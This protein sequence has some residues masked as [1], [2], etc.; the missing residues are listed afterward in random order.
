[1]KKD[2][3]SA[4]GI[5]QS[6][7]LEWMQETTNLILAGFSEIEIKERL[8]GFLSNRS[9]SGKPILRSKN[10]TEF[11]RA[12]L[13]KCWVH[14][15]PELIPLRDAGLAILS[16][17]MNNVTP[18]HFGM[19]SAA[20]PY[21]YNVAFHLGRLLNLQETVDA[22]RVLMRIRE[23]Y[24]DKQTITR[25]ADYV[26]RSLIAW[27]LIED[28]DRKG[29]YIRGKRIV[30]EEPQCAAFLLAASFYAVDSRN[31]DF[32]SLRH[33][34]ALFAFDLHNVSPEDLPKV[35]SSLEITRVR[36]DTIVSR[37][38]CSFVQTASKTVPR[39]SSSSR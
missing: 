20:Y 5:K 37:P 9:G 10:T 2:R 24:G 32:E 39:A 36:N 8:S 16:D 17:R 30:I 15:E 25:T 35:C 12:V 21:W 31:T 27:G 34:P 6:I 19:M 18:I 23:N 38:S 7:R 29:N 33:S 26:F 1:M 4:I 28:K 22:S 11:A 3:F 13:M 14:P